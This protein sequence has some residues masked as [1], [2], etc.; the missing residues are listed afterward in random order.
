[1]T[2]KLETYTNEQ[3]AQELER[4]ATEKEQ[5]SKVPEPLEVIDWSK[6]RELCV[7]HILEMADVDYGDYCNDGLY[8][9]RIGNAAI[10]AVFGP[11][12]QE[13]RNKHFYVSPK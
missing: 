11:D 5:L 1:M 13:W 6:V 2:S 3:L 9:H 12:I 10:E 8:E 7:K 4:R